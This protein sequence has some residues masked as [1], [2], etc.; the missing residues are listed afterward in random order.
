MRAKPPVVLR[1][2]DL[3]RQRLVNVIDAGQELV[4]FAEM[5]DWTVFDGRFGAYFVSTTGRTTLPTRLIAGLL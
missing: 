4:R 1:V 2:G 3:F 5:I